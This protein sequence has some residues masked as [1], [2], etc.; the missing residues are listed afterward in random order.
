MAGGF[1]HIGVT[2][3]GFPLRRITLRGPFVSHH[4]L[5]DKHNPDIAGEIDSLVQDVRECGEDAPA[6]NFEVLEDY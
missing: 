1:V 4:L 2:V 3:R 6:L 5:L